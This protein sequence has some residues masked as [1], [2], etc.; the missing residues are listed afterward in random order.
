MGIEIERKFLIADDS[1]REQAG[2]GE[3]YRQGYLF[4]GQHCS[5]RLRAAGDRAWLNVKGATVGAA[6][7]EF[8]YDVPHADAIAMLDDLCDPGQ[9]DK[10][11]YRVPVGRHCFEVDVFHGA[12]EGL[13][14]AE[15]ELAAPDEAFERPSWLGAE[16]TDDT[17]YYNAR[18]A[19][20]PWSEWGASA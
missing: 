13:V 1:W 16:V 5:V 15:V 19:R 3:R 20:E 11:R 14:V 10:T 2:E 18:L 8:E 9:I 4:T 6:R 12:N 7:P 17:R